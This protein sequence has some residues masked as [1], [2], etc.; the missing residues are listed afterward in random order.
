M[1][2]EL[3]DLRQ[4]VAEVRNIVVV[5]LNKA[6]SKV[7]DLETE[8]AA[9]RSMHTDYRNKVTALLK[10]LDA[11]KLADPAQPTP[12]GPPAPPSPPA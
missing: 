11:L 1:A 9:E 5:E 2:D 6:R 12:E 7:A 10:E 4:R 8:L 3:D